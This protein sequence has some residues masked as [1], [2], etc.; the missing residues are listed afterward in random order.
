MTPTDSFELSVTAV[1]RLGTCGT[2]HFRD[3]H[4]RQHQ[5]AGC[6]MSVAHP[7]VQV[8]DVEEW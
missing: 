5:R 3:G 1:H 6:E 4:R 7:R 2:R 8:I